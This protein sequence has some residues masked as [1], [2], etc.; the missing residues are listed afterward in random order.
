MTSEAELK[1]QIETQE[2]ELRKL[3]HSVTRAE[4]ENAQTLNTLKQRDN[5]IT[6]RDSEIHDL[7]AQ[8][9]TLN[10]QNTAPNN[11]LNNQRTSH[12]ISAAPSTLCRRV[13]THFF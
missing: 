13:L 9:Q 11:T 4:Q 7:Q 6:T 3:R 2:R 1:S 5:E 10:T 12:I 8:L